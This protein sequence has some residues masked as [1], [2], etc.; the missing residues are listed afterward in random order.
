V[1]AAMQANTRLQYDRQRVR[2]AAQARTRLQERQDVS[3]AAQASTPLQIGPRVRRASHWGR[4]DPA[5][6]G[7]TVPQANT[8]R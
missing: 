5:Q 2:T 6:D 7:T 3:P 8:R 4:I 1:F